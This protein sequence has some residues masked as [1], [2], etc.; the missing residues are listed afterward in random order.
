MGP[1][2]RGVNNAD[3]RGLDIDDSEETKLLSAQL[4]RGTWATAG[5]GG[6]LSGLPLLTL[7]PPLRDSCANC[8][9]F[10]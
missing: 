8:F 7:G 10:S 3:E 1:T 9:F 5:L 2:P 4:D 6:P